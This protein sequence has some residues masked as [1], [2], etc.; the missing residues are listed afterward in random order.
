MHKKIKN[1]KLFLGLV[2][3]YC[4]F[5]A[6]SLQT[7]SLELAGSKLQGFILTI[8]VTTLN[9]LLSTL[10]MYKGLVFVR[11]YI[12]K[13][14]TNLKLTLVFPLMA[15]VDYLV[16]LIPAT[17][18]IG[19]QGRLGSLLPIGSPTV[20]LINSPIK[21]ASRLV[22]FFGLAGLFWGL[23]I[24]LSI[25]GK[26]R[27]T[28]VSTAAVIVLALAGQ[29]AYSEINGT[30]I[31]TKII[32]E[33]LSSRAAQIKVEDVNLVIFPEYGLDRIN[34]SN[35][36]S[37]IERTDKLQPKTYF[38]GTEQLFVKDEI[39]HLNTIDYGNTY[40]GITNKKD[41]Y[42]LIPGGEDLPYA[43]RVLLRATGQTKTLDYFSLTKGTLK[44]A[45]K[46]EPF[47]LDDNT[48]VG[49]TPC[50]S[51]LAPQD[52]RYL[53]NKGATILTNS[54]SLSIFKGSRLFSWEQKSFAKFMAVANSRY[55]LQ[56][57]NSATA[58]AIDNN[59]KT[60]AEFEGNKGVVV[61]VKNNTKKTLYT[62]FSDWLVVVGWTTVF[63]I[64][65]T[66]LYK[67]RKR[68]LEHQLKIHH[69]INKP[70]KR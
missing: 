9:V 56:S 6:W 3:W 28:L 30:T 13:H 18:W 36:N 25:K 55:F 47:T 11:E 16:A 59:G 62:M 21:Y 39:G 1:K 64:I 20:L 49:A 29:I 44:G 50:S 7:D 57:A 68:L 42:R 4:V 67:S 52:Y 60:I 31:K 37:R 19:P 32:S 45:N 8:F 69:K 5:W 27:H 2:I 38:V 46:V 33:S 40:D 34:N 12:V 41:K 65:V 43:V 66:K 24:L 14:Q 35:L 63:I 48:V 10:V 23:L 70:K 17:V 26:K 61:E 54:A 58:Y 53:V 51:I 15:F 22:G